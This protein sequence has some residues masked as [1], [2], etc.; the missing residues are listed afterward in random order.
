MDFGG[1]KV[2]MISS[3]RNILAPGSAV[4]ERMKEYGRLVEEL[5]IVLLSDAKHGLKNT[6]LDKN[7][8]VYPTNSTWKYFRPYNAARI[9]KGIVLGAKFVRG[10]ALI[11]AQDPFECGLAALKIKLKWRL[12]LEVQL[13]TNPFSS[14]FTGFLN[15]LRKRIAQN[16]LR[17][18][19]SL[20]TVTTVLAERMAKEFDLVG[21]TFVLP[22]YIDMKKLR[23]AYIP[24]DLHDRVGWKVV[25]LAVS[26]LTAEKHI[27]LLLESLK[28]VL[29]SYSNV[30]LVVVGDGVEKERLMNLAHTL[31]IE[32]HVIFTGWQEN[33]APYYK[34]ATIFV[35][36]SYFEGYGLSL[37]EAGLS[38]LPIVTTDVGLAEELKDG[39]DV[40]ISAPYPDVFAASILQL[41]QDQTF[42]QT[43]G[44]TIQKTLESKLVTKEE[45]LKK[46]KENWEKIA[47]NIQP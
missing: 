37:V 18:A 24:F 25:L 43:L 40:R 29:K 17:H 13:H 14:Y 16:V 2:L 6:Q 19:D 36:T 38:G 9:G 1:L 33:L 21:K 42:A 11:T 46:L 35:Q 8:F 10:R 23:E 3:D 47:L 4:A 12:P 28:R 7:V 41:I 15:T 45:Y 27:D 31:G 34:G 44:S 5:H 20:R 39:V 32:Q 26:R 30:G 22:I